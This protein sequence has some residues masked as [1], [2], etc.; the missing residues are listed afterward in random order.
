MKEEHKNGERRDGRFIKDSTRASRD[1]NKISK[2]KNT[3]DGYN[4]RLDIAEEKNS[5]HK[6]IEKESIHT[7]TQRGKTRTQSISELCNNSK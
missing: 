4:G 6:D 3:L 1:K 2:I 5:E 7:E